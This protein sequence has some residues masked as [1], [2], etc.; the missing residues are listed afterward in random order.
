MGKMAAMLAHEMNQPLMAITNAIGIL[1]KQLSTGSHDVCELRE[2]VDFIRQAS[3]RSGELL[4]RIRNFFQKRAT[5]FS[6]TDIN[7]AVDHVLRMSAA[8]LRDAEVELHTFLA[9]DLPKV[10]A[11]PIQIEQV[12]LNLVQNAVE[13]MQHLD[14]ECRLDITTRAD[15]TGV[16]VSVCDTGCGLP[17]QFS[18]KSFPPFSSTKPEG[19]GMGLSICEAI[20][21]VHGGSLSASLNK[22]AGTSFC[23][24]LP[25]PRQD[26]GHE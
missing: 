8:L 19:L 23:F 25:L 13:S 18:G 24:V 7:A 15:A 10:M 6:E 5:T 2:S 1:D 16:Q 11:D 3:L 22:E 20:L 4:W 21:D 12:L 9:P 14:A 26:H 17:V